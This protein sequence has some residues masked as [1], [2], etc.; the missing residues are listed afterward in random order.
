MSRNFMNRDFLRWLTTC[1]LVILAILLLA[2]NL[3][4][5][6]SASGAN[7][8]SS[9]KQSVSSQNQITPAPLSLTLEKTYCQITL[10]INSD[11]LVNNSQSAIT[12]TENQIKE[13][14]F[15]KDRQAGLAIIYVNDPNP[16]PD[17][18]DKSHIIATKIYN[19]L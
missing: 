15:L 8:P 11:E 2:L 10:M 14:S 16:N 19:I 3:V 4:S 5:F 13:K 9:G 7:N 1:L 12:D 17:S 6:A 18:K